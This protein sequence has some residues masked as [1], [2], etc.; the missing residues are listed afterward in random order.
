MAPNSLVQ[1]LQ[2]INYKPKV[3]KLCKF[4]RVLQYH[5]SP[6][7]WSH[8]SVIQMKWCYFICV[9][10]Q[11]MTLDE[12]NTTIYQPQRSEYHRGHRPRW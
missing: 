11:L 10:I 9:I 1:T 2:S 12:V 7:G 5:A 6:P 4:I 8:I 3:T